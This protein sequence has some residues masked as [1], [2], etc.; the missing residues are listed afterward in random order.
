MRLLYPARP[1]SCAVAASHRSARV[2]AVYDRSYYKQG[3]CSASA[4]WSSGLY[5]C[6][7]RR[8]RYNAPYQRAAEPYSIV[9][10]NFASAAPLH[11]VVRPRSS[12][13]ATTA[14][15]RL[16]LFASALSYSTS[17]SDGA[18][19]SSFYLSAHLHF[20]LHQPLPRRSNDSHQRGRE[21]H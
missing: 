4:T 13:P 10:T 3:C 19:I 2:L 9:H 1:Y 14:L 5:T 6:S 17:C 11:T 7:L 16:H 20:Y 8:G 15:P 12:T 21:P 18:S